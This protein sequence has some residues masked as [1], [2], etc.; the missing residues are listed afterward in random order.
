MFVASFEKGA[1]QTDAIIGGPPNPEQD[2]EENVISVFVSRVIDPD[3][4]FK[5]SVRTIFL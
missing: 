5:T 1:S 4:P 3:N 2:N